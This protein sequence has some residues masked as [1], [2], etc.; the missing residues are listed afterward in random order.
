MARHRRFDFASIATPVPIRDSAVRILQQ[1][2]ASGILDLDRAKWI[3][4]DIIDPDPNQFRKH[5]DETALRDLALNIL[6]QGVLQPIIVEWIAETGRFRIIAGERRR[7]AIQLAAQLQTE[8]PSI[9][10]RDLSRLPAI[11][12]DPS[13]VER[14]LQQVSENE[15]R[16]D[17]SDVERAFAYERLKALLDVTWDELATKLGLSRQR[18][19]QIRSMKNRLTES[20]RDDITQ[21]RIT[22]RQARKLVLLPPPAQEAVATVIK[23]QNLTHQQ[24]DALVQR[25]RK[26]I[27]AKPLP[28]PVKLT[29]QS[30]S[31]AP[32]ATV[33]SDI[34]ESPTATLQPWLTAV[35]DEAAR[36]VVRTGI[37]RP[38]DQGP[39]EKPQAESPAVAPIEAFLSWIDQRARFDELQPEAARADPRLLP[40]LAELIGWATA[41]RARLGGNVNH[42]LHQDESN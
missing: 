22:E 35:I 12:R 30:D 6:A 1:E 40:A 21:K 19:H 15:S 31:S 16:E 24:T 5:F 17:Y 7:R 26:V 27:Q 42:G 37:L 20:V 18:I 33:G 36:E 11:V 3:P 9:S 2:P 23:D 34:K 10:S 28:D 8:D 29:E 13:L 25:V 39:A 41:L 32:P 4:V 14:C 38:I